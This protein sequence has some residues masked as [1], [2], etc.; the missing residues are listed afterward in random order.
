MYE[1][2]CSLR[3][4]RRRSCAHLHKQAHVV[5]GLRG[6]HLGW[7]QMRIVVHIQSRR[8]AFDAAQQQMT[9]G[10]EADRAHQQRIFDRR[11]L[12]LQGEGLHQAKHLHILAAAV[13]LEPGFEQT[14][15]LR[16]ALR[17]LPAGERRR[18]VQRSSLLFE[19]RQVVQ[20]IED[21]ASRS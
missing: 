18:L 14:P 7:R 5:G 6:A 21:T 1:L 16:K 8:P 17:Q 15:Q 9:N 2:Q 12:L 10:V 19:Q 3:K 4:S 13:L 20:R 11:E